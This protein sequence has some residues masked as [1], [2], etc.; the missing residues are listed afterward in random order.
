MGI[1]D[2][3]WYRKQPSR[4]GSW[5]HE[6]D[7]VGKVLVLI[8]VAC[9]VGLVLMKVLPRKQSFEPDLD[10]L[11]FGRLTGHPVE[12]HGMHAA[13]ES[14]DTGKVQA[15]LM[16]EP[17]QAWATLDLDNPDLPVHHAARKGNL[18][19]VTFLLAFNGLQGCDVRDG[20]RVQVNRSRHERLLSVLRPATC[21]A[22]PPSPRGRSVTARPWWDSAVAPALS[23]CPAALGW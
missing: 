10:D 13:I 3:D 15:L 7:T 5:W 2:R 9:I 6:L 21:Q 20:H 11:P 8:F 22:F 1:Y 12:D 17:T 18:Q 4:I 23:R 14:D 16:R 19:L